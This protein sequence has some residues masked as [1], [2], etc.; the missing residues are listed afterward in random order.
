MKNYAIIVSLCAFCYN[1]SVLFLYFKIISPPDKIKS[2]LEELI[3][4][5]GDNTPKALSGLKNEVNRPRAGEAIAR[6]KEKVSQTA[7]GALREIVKLKDDLLKNPEDRKALLGLAGTALLAWCLMPEVKEKDAKEE[8]GKTKKKDESAN[9]SEKVDQK[10]AQPEVKY[11]AVTP[12]ATP[13]EVLSAIRTNATTLDEL[14]AKYKKEKNPTELKYFLV[15]AIIAKETGYKTSPEVAA[16]LINVYAVTPKKVEEFRKRGIVF[17]MPAGS[18]DLLPNE[19]FL[20]DSKDG[21]E[22]FKIRVCSQ[23]QPNV[24]EPARTNN[25]AEILMH[26]AIGMG[27]ILPVYYIEGMNNADGKTRLRKIFD[28]IKNWQGQEAVT[29]RTVERLGKLYD[30]NPACIAAAYYGGERSGNIV[31]DNSKSA[32]LDKKQA[33]GYGS[34]NTYVQRVDS[35]VK[36][37][38]EDQKTT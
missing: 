5:F 31:R 6:A 13:A 9:N 33:Y 2:P 27:Q 35:L 8:A 11:A 14:Y 12:K 1:K 36:K 26:S 30:W 34:I 19:S 32:S 10:K 7:G 23:L 17:N 16:R 25:T 15:K 20:K 24:P 29:A 4:G 37:I 21:F 3:S 22:A 18:R 28:F 38:I